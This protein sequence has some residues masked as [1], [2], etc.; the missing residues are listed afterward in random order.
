MGR[1]K[2]AVSLHLKEEVTMGVFIRVE[3]D[4]KKCLGLAKSGECV[5]ICPVNIFEGKE[6]RVVVKEENEDE[7]TL[8][9]LCLSKCQPSAIA[10]KKLY[11]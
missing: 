5:R 7:C 10:I 9:N 6:G 8:C 1:R 2:E 4:E 11:E 3:I